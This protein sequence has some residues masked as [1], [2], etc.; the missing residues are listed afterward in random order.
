MPYTATLPARW[1]RIT[2]AVLLGMS[3]TRCSPLLAPVYHLDMSDE[4]HMQASIQQMEEALPDDQR[5]VF[6]H[7][8]QQL[9]TSLT[10]Q[11]INRWAA[12]PASVPPLSLSKLNGL[13]AED[14]IAQA[15]QISP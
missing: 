3:I 8:L 6:E 9:V 2:L 13:T 4:E 11:D 7:A 5:A 12:A 10:Q 1:F 14:I 15:R